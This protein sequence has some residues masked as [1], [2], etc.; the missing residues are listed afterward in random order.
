MTSFR[1]R[2]EAHYA[3][4]IETYKRFWA[5]VLRTFAAPQF[6]RLPAAR[7]DTGAHRPHRGLDL[8]SG[9]GAHDAE[10][11]RVLGPKSVLVAGDVTAAMVRESRLAAPSSHPVLLDASRLPFADGVFDAIFCLF[12]LH[13]IREQRRAMAECCRALESR[14]RLAVVVWAAGD[15]GGTEFQLFEQLL[16]KWGAPETDPAPVPAWS[17]NIDT[18]DSLRGMLESVGLDEVDCRQETVTYRWSPDALLGYLTGHGGTHRRFKGLPES[19]QRSGLVEARKRFEEL[20][21]AE[22][23]WSPDIVYAV[24][25]RAAPRPGRR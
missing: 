13:H 18:P 16:S 21:E 8:G 2:I 23:K 24:A 10:I 7:D 6:E 20:S 22:L 25:R 9:V 11:R 3:P 5:P 17:E 15:P 4:S 12:V 1:D 14:G 19:R